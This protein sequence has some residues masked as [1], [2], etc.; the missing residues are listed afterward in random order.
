MA[1]RTRKFVG[2][3]VC[4]ECKTP[5]L[6]YRNDVLTDTP[7]CRKARSRRLQ[8]EAVA[9]AARKKR[10]RKGGKADG[11]RSTGRKAKP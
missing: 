10:D 2:E 1:Q 8:A 11:R 3:F 4:T 6:G 5:F 7:R 9:L